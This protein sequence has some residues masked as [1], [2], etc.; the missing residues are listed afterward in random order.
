MSAYTFGILT[1]LSRREV[2]IRGS[3]PLLSGGFG[4]S[5]QE[6]PLILATDKSKGAERNYTSA[7]SPQKSE[8]TIGSRVRIIRGKSL[9]ASGII[10]SIPPEPEM[11]AAG[12]I[13]PGAKVKLNNEV[14]YIP[15]A[16]LEQ[17]D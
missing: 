11:T 9:G 1:S 3:N 13:A 2:S 16:N 8:V 15:W 4:T 17:I 10:D 12:I 14:V 6:P 7:K 5:R